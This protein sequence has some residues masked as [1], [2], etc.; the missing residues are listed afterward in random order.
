MQFSEFDE[1][2]IKGILDP[3]DSFD[4]LPE[5]AKQR[6]EAFEVWV[7]GT[8][9]PVFGDRSRST[10]GRIIP[11]EAARDFMAAL[12]KGQVPDW[13]ADLAPLKEIRKMEARA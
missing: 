12:R 6:I 2:A 10:N 11:Q 5:S 4:A 13:V 8:Y 3:V 9:G 1:K 7:E